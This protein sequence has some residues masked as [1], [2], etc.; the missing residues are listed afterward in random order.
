MANNIDL[1]TLADDELKQIHA[2]A[3]ELLSARKQ[4]RQ[5]AVVEEIKTKLAEA[6]LTLRDLARTGKRSAHKS[7]PATRPG[8]TLTN[9]KD[10]GQ[11]WTPGRGRPPKWVSEL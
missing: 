3:G 8:E 10:P 1:E 7:K 4:E 2:R 11:T 6:G 9:P 5:Q